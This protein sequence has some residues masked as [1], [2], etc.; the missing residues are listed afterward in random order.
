MDKFNGLCKLM[1]NFSNV[2]IAFSGGVDSTLLAYLAQK[3]FED[4]AL[5]VTAVS[6]MYTRIQ[7]HQSQAIANALN[8]QHQS[9]IVNV[10]DDEQILMN[11]TDRCYWCKKVIFG[12]LKK[13]AEERGAVLL[14]G[15]NYDDQTDYRPGEKA[16]RELGVRS[17]FQELAITKEEIRQYSKEL[18]LPTWNH[19]SESCLAT[20]IAYGDHLS[21]ERLQRIEFAEAFLYELGLVQTRVRDHAG[22]ARVEIPADRLEEAWEKREQIKIKLH[23]LGFTYVSLDLDGFRS[24]SM[25][26]GQK[27][28]QEQVN[29][30]DAELETD[31]TELT[32]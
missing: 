16:A 13:I 24:G 19:P 11:G 12:E 2:V 9:V 15:T 28:A 25:N 29:P 21:L 18:C 27:L 4:R 8:L 22:L 31:E 6:P 17:P 23:E 3:I 26:L 30:N 20:R 1:G 32:V 14:D 5:A 7:Q 10:L